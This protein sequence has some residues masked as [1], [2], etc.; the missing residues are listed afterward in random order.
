MR[1]SGEYPRRNAVANGVCMPWYAHPV[2]KRL[3]RRA[4]GVVVSKGWHEAS[5]KATRFRAAEE[6]S[7]RAPSGSNSRR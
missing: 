2:D 1:V 3:R 5:V 6:V 4:R 7:G